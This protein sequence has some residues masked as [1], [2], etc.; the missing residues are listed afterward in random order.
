MNLLFLFDFGKTITEGFFSIFLFIDGKIFS[1]VSSAYKIFMALAGARLFTNDMYVS[2]ANSVYF[3]IGVAMLFVLSYAIIKGIIDPDK[4][5][6]GE[7]IGSKMVKSIL[8]AVLGLALTPVMFNVLYQAQG[9]VLDNNIIGKIIFRSTAYDS[10]NINYTTTDENGNDSSINVDVVTDDYISQIGGGYT[11]VTL[12]QAFFRPSDDQLEDNSAEAFDKAAKNIVGDPSKYFFSNAATW[13]SALLAGVVAVG[14]VATEVVTGG[15]ATPFLIAGA[16]AIAVGGYNAVDNIKSGI[17][18]YGEERTLAEAYAYA[19]ASGDFGI[20][21]IFVPNIIGD[22]DKGGEISYSVPMLAI[23]GA[24]VLYSFVSFSIDMGVRAAKLAYYQ[25]IAPVPLIMQVIPKFKSNFD[26][27]I[28]SVINTFLEVVVRVLVIYVVVYL[29]MHISDLFGSIDFK[30]TNL[31]GAEKIIATALLIIGLILFAKKAPQIITSTLGIK[32]GDLKFGIGKKLAEGEVFTAGA[33]LGSMATSG[34]RNFRNTWSEAPN[35]TG[36]TKR[37]GKSVVSGVGGVGGAA[38][39]SVTGRIVSGKPVAT[40]RDMRNIAGKTSN[41]TT[42]AR[43]DRKDWYDSHSKGGSRNK[44]TTFVL[45]HAEDLGRTINAWS[46]GTVN[47]EKEQA[48]MK[49]T[50]SLDSLKGNLR[51]EAYKKDSIAKALKQQMESLKSQEVSKYRDG[52][53]DEIVA[54]EVKKRAATTYAGMSAEQIANKAVDKA[55]DDYKKLKNDIDAAK[56]AGNVKKA[57]ELEKHLESRKNALNRANDDLQAAKLGL[58]SEQEII[59]RMVNNDALLDDAD[60]SKKILQRQSEIEGYRQAMEARADSFII[61]KAS[62]SNSN[63]YKDIQAFLQENASYI[64]SNLSTVLN[65]DSNLTVQQ[66]IDET[67]GESVASNG[68]L[69]KTAAASFFG[70]QK[71]TITVGENKVNKKVPGTYE[72][73]TYKRND[74]GNFDEYLTNVKVTS[75]GTVSTTAENKIGSVS[76]EDFYGRIA[77]EAAAS[78][79]DVKSHTTISDGT[80]TASDTYKVVNNKY[81]AKVQRKAEQEKKN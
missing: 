49:F 28:K 32:G 65:S 52:W 15:L 12:W 33:A 69:D 19:G 79:K 76:K 77:V 23:C 34:I 71:D 78:G 72:Y 6:K 3:I 80:S 39:R 46:A 37:L 31:S 59:G 22:N 81:T 66:L 50:K 7:M 41:E 11:A 74:D 70:I 25:I 44:A 5:A 26:N 4:A 18:H 55:K 1:L 14:L 43:Q 27:Y 45:G 68:S 2:I 62:D 24:F 61:E 75:D 56:A 29:I 16:T 47:T 40:A 35:G 20:F 58:I 73:K 9:I 8:I 63:T 17:T 67:F 48:A 64:A 38:R 21:S 30:G 54:E 13:T 10:G 57:T 36:F 53:S 60:Y 42:K 51:E